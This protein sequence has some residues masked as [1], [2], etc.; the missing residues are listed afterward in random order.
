MQGRHRKTPCSNCAGK[1]MKS[2]YEW[3]RKAQRCLRMLSGLHRLGFQH[4][5]GIPY[6]NAQGCTFA[7]APRH[8]F[9]DNGIAIPAA[10]LSDE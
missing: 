7:I 10:K 1:M 8:Y 6:F 2:K 9:S 3:I 4:L 5:R